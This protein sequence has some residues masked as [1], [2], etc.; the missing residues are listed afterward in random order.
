MMLEEWY[1]TIQSL[2]LIFCCLL[3]LGVVL[4]LWL[5]ALVDTGVSYALNL[6]KDEEE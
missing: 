3:P 1:F 4:L 5:F 6:P 2:L